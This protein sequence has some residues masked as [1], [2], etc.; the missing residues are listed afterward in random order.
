MML[1]LLLLAQAETVPVPGTK[2]DVQLLRVP[3]GKTKPFWMSKTE[4]PAD[5]FMEYYQRREAVKVDGVTRPSAPYEP[6]VGDMAVA[7]H[8]AVGMRW[9]G[10]QGYCA[11]LSKK[12]GHKFRLPT[13]A[14][15]EAAAAGTSADTAW[16]AENADKKTHALGT[17][18]ANPLGFHDLLGNVWEYCLEPMTPG[19]YAPVLRGGAWN[20]PKAELSLG[21]RQGILPTWFDRDPNRPRSLWWLTDA[22]FVGL[23]VVRVGEASTQE[24]QKAYAAKI[25]V[26]N[27][28]LAEPA[29]QM[30]AVTGEIVNAG[31]KELWEVEL[32]VH[33]LDADDKPLTED[34]K[35][36]PTFTQAYPVLANAWHAGPHQAPLKPGESRAFT[37]L[38]P[39]A[40]EVPTDP[41]KA[42][43]VVTGVRFSD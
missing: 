1:I 4:M 37:A 27:L 24:A 12:T 2:Y 9:H 28:K 42:A 20:T 3:A 36:R 26:R 23:R 25:E 30:V 43:A 40:Y 29:K 32:T 10:A 21:T 39:Q 38:V 5:A 33:F 35:A 14:E 34:E 15:W 16:C 22:R 11:W 41:V 17:R 6:P 18:G 19:E 31:D 13:E 8:P 7:G